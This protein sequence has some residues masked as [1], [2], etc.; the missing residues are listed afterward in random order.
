MGA[1][2]AS[3]GKPGR[4]VVLAGAGAFGRRLADG[5]AATTRLEVV[6]AGRSRERAEA[7]A[8]ALGRAHPGGRL[9]GIALDRDDP[10]PEA[11]RAL[12]PAILVDAAGPFQHGSFGLARAAIAAGLH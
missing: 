2:A 9:P 6:V 5:L 7:A 8:R 1:P 11:W 3:R 4:V 12:A 10:D